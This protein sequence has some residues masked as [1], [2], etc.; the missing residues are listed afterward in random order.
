LK[1]EGKVALITG[2]S[3][4]MGAAL[5]QALALEGVKVVAVARNEQRLV[6]VMNM[7]PTDVRSRVTTILTDVQN[8]AQVRSAVISTLEQHGHID[9]LLNCAGVSMHALQRLE[10]TTSE[11]WQRIMDTN[12]YGTYLFSREVIPSMKRQNFG[13]IINI[14]STAAFTASNG[15][16]LYAASKYGARALT[17]ALIEENRNSGIRIS[18]VS[19]GPVNTNIWSHKTEFVSDE[20]RAKMLEVTDIVRIVLFL[21]TQPDYVVIDNITVTP[22]VR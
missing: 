16:S 17:E 7:L 20:R 14:L 2:G 15:Y 10:E 8:E 6:E 1:L 21:L 12:V 4:G 5:V 19:P 9:I 18:S 3:E 22:G 13:Y 11:D